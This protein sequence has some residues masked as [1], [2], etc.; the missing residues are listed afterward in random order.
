MQTNETHDPDLVSWVDSAN[1]G[2][3]DFPI[4]NLPFAVFRRRDAHEPYRVGVA[5]GDQI[6][7]ISLASS[8][9]PFPESAENAVVACTNDSLN[10]LMKLGQPAWHELR[11]A[12]SQ[13]LRRGS[14]SAEVLASCL[15]GQTEAEY[16]VPAQIG[17]YTD[18]YTS[19]EHAT[20]IGRLFRP[21]NPLMPNYQWLPIAY[22]GR[23][24]SI[25]ISGEPV[26]RPV[27]QLKLPEQDQPVL[28]PCRRLDYEMEVGIYI[29]TG[30]P[31]N[32]P[33]AIDDA[34]RHVFGLCLLNDWS[35]R[36]IQAWEYQ[37]LGPFLAKNFATTVSP[38]VVTSEALI[39]LRSKWHRPPGDPQP[40]P[41]LESET[42]RSFGAYDI[43]LEVRIQTTS[44]RSTGAQPERLSLANFKGS[45]WTVAQ[46]LAHHTIGGC[47]LNPGDLFGSG[48]QSGPTQAE[49]GALIELTRGGVEPVVLS[50]GERRS[51]LEDGDT[52]SFH[53][54]GE[55]ATGVRIGFGEASGTIVASQCG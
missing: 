6:L 14:E 16:R 31:R 20:N 37:P 53:A 40:L 5:I 50:N 23:S 54:W 19:I 7:D 9:A 49:G 25:V 32:Q 30:N 28:A 38:W 55:P 2:D 18:F 35:A 44:M 1:T 36:D 11:R 41:Y 46:M 48:T 24:S 34:E 8:H 22:H 21:D 39:P 47:N 42:N 29:G 33:I 43:N 52:V 17:D 13:A 12:L 51:F 26:E 10:P 27:G 45:Y 4:Q 15:V 3:S